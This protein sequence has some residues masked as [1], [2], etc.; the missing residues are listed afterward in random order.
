MGD[1]DDPEDRARVHWSVPP[2]PPGAMSSETMSPGLGEEF[3]FHLYR[4]SELLR[5]DQ[6]YEAKSELERALSLQP[7]DVESQSLLGVTYFR[8]GHYPRAIQIYEE[9]VRERPSEVAPRVNLGLCYL[10]T[11]Q[12]GLARTLLEELVQ[13]KPD[14]TRAWGYLGLTFQ[15]LGD[16]DKAAVAFDRAGRPQL[17]AR[18]RASSGPASEAAIESNHDPAPST[19]QEITADQVRAAKTVPP[20]PVAVPEARVSTPPESVRRPSGAHSMAPG[21]RVSIPAP[22]DRV[23]RDSLLVF[24]ERPRVVLHESGSVLAR[25]EGSFN[26]R[27]D[28]LRALAP[29]SPGSVARTLLRRKARA[30]I[31]EEP[32]GGTVTPFVALEGQGRV[33]LTVPAPFTPMVA[34]LDGEPL[35]VLEERLVAFDGA[36]AHSVGRLPFADGTSG[37]LVQLIG[38]GFV[39][40]GTRPPLHALETTGRPLEARTKHLVGWIGRMIPRPISRDEAPAALADLLSLSGSGT[41]LIDG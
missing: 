5:D 25:I 1:P 10:K 36:L 17:A 38:S 15:R 18:L 12:L 14:H 34:T 26:A 16:Y 20:P 29:E 2:P 39:V 4:G 22:L 19:V 27:S 41:V 31:A 32:L 3:L 40:I 7:R 33:V 11:G 35:Y 28:C 24:P 37:G 6:I 23:A 30:G 8:L 9:L 21:T 13:H